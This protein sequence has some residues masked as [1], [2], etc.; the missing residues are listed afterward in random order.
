M[1]ITYI[2]RNITTVTFGVIAQGVNC[3]GAM[4]S[5]VAKAIKDTWPVVSERYHELVHG[6]NL[7]LIG[8][9]QLVEIDS[10]TLYVANCFTQKFYGR[11]GRFAIPT[12]IASS[13]HLVKAYSSYYGLPV[14]MPKIGCG[15][16]G[17]NW[18]SEVRDI[19]EDTFA[20]HDQDI[21]VCGL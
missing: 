1:S 13:L 8:T 10:D 9:C 17:L 11:S 3:S 15:L 18:D 7:G 5:G 6:G 2:T 20:N 16:G 14:I 4:N 12:A 19:V 21:Y